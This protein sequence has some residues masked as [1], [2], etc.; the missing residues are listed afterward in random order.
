MQ[1]T[2]AP[3]I[4]SCPGDITVHPVAG[5]CNSAAVTYSGS[6]SDNCGA[7]TITFDPPSGS[8]FGPGT[9]TVTMYAED[10]CGNINDSCTFTVTNDGMNELVVDVELGGGVMVGGSYT[11]CITFELW[12]GLTLAHTATAEI[13]FTGGNAA[14]VTLS[15]PCNAGPYTCITARDRK[16]T[17]RE[18]IGSVP[19]NL[20]G[21]YTA[22]FIGSSKLIGGNFNDDRFIDILDF[23]IF[24]TQDLTIQPANTL[25]GYMPR[26]ADADGDGMVGSADFGFVTLNFLSVRD[27]N[28]NGASLTAPGGQ[29]DAPVT[30]ISVEELQKQGMA[31]LIRADLDR[32]GWLDQADVSAY[33]NG[34]RPGDEPTGPTP[35]SRPIGGQTPGLRPTGP[36]SPLK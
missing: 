13:G 18:T 1:D 35:Q 19:T 31:E 12:N 33:M 27:L 21:Q 25:C 10:E 26:N 34:V 23:G 20:S 4:T 17:L 5:G 15:V 22:D 11:R 14:P 9:H 8:T 6:A 2:T 29:G 28:C 32:D 30:R 36:T 16:H 7:A 3:T 24:T